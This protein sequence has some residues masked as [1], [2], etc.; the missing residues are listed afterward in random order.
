MSEK[1]QYS[2]VYRSPLDHIKYLKTKSLGFR[3][4]DD[5]YDYLNKPEEM[6]VV[7]NIH[8][9]PEGSP[10]MEGYDQGPFNG[11]SSD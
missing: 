2:K 6:T 8:V 5:A 10:S 4:E 7:G 1:I 3:C 9:M 11:A